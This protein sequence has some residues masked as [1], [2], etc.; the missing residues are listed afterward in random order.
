MRL[1]FSRTGEFSS[2][3]L[4]FFPATLHILFYHYIR[5]PPYCKGFVYWN[6]SGNFLWNGLGAGRGQ[7]KAGGYAIFWLGWNGE[8]RLSPEAVTPSHASGGDHRV[9]FRAPIYAHGMLLRVFLPF[10]YWVGM[11]A[12]LPTEVPSKS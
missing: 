9:A 11:L 3:L 8:L 7:T 10:N 6:F 1:L 12:L 5:F 4:F 2:V